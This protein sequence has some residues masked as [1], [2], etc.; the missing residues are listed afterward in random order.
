[1][2]IAIGLW[3]VTTRR[4][5]QLTFILLQELGLAIWKARARYT[6]SGC[7]NHQCSPR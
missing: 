2:S 3:Y 5:G 7:S 6:P 4:P 1:M